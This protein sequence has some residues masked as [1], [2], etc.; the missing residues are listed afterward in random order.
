[1]VFFLTDSRGQ[2]IDAKWAETKTASLRFVHI[3]TCITV[4]CKS[5]ANEN[6]RISLT[7]LSKSH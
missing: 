1:M 6:R 5:N 3:F 7:V 2:L 4:L